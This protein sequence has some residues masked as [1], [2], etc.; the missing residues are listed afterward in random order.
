VKEKVKIGVGAFVGL[1][2]VVIRDVPANTVVVGNPAT[3]LKRK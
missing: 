2:S 3:I 1:G